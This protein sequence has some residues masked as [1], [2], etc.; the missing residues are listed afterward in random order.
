MAHVQQHKIINNG[1]NIINWLEYWVKLQIDGD[2]EH[3]QGIS[4]TMFD[5]P[6]WNM[7]IYLVHYEPLEDDI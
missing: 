5:N 3:E 2:W 6:G 4:I 7:V 1:K